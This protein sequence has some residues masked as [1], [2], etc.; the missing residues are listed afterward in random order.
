[1]KIIYFSLY[2][3]L[4]SSSIL[5]KVIKPNFAFNLETL[6]NFY[7]GIQFQN[8]DKKAKLL[9]IKDGFNYYKQAFSHQQYQLDLLITVNPATKKIHQLEIHF[10]SYFL[11]DDLLARLQK[12]YGKQNQFKNKD[13]HSVYIWKNAKQLRII[14]E[15]GCSIT[16][17]PIFLSMKKIN[18]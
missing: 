6:K 9:G 12:S 18:I 14:Y 2:V 1:M 8:Q 17:F 4:F 13:Q 15:A 10:P 7:P 16:C 3:F 11:H 5:A